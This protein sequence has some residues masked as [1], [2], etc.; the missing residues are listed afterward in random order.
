MWL[1]TGLSF[2]NLLRRK[3]QSVECHR[4]FLPRSLLFYLVRVLET[5]GVLLQRSSSHSQV[6][7][8]P[9]SSTIVLHREMDVTLS[10]EKLLRHYPHLSDFKNTGNHHSWPIST[11]LWK[12]RL[13]QPHPNGIQKT[14]FKQ[15][16]CIHWP[17][18]YL[19]I[20]LRR[21]SCVLLLLRPVQCLRHCWVLYSIGA[22]VLCRCERKVLE[23]DKSQM[24]RDLVDLRFLML[25]VDWRKN[26]Q[27]KWDILYSWWSW[28]LPWTPQCS[29]IN[30]SS[31][32]L[33]HPSC[34]R[35]W[36]HVTQKWHHQ[37]GSGLKK[38]GEGLELAFWVHNWV[39]ESSNY[40]STLPIISHF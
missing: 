13:S 25:Q 19:Q 29:V 38:V 2:L 26:D 3:Q 8:R 7:S 40:Q 27:G 18:I 20:H 17:R 22:L 31:W 37:T 6:C 28:S 32:D 23:A 15:W 4:V 34:D 11:D 10:S 9:L 14:G 35:K 33:H 16:F 36:P 1:G 30:K 21:R 5:N 39:W 12:C 24:F